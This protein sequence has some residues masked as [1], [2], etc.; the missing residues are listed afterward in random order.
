MLD[1]AYATLSGDKKGAA[2]HN[3][4]LANDTFPKL[5]RGDSYNYTYVK[6]GP[7]WFPEGGYV[8]FHELS[9]IED[10]TL[11]IE[12]IIEKNIIGKLDHI[13]Y[14]IGLS[15]DMLRPPKDKF[16]GRDLSIEDFQ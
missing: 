13:M 7:T 8:A 6:D 2:W 16:D 15:N 1:K 9:Q 3:I 11:D 12:K 10:Y 4:V 5:D 14:G